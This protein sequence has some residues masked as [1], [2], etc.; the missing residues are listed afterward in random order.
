M[1]TNN[2]IPFIPF[3]ATSPITD[4]IALF[5]VVTKKLVGVKA[6]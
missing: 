4:Y 5:E 6:A 2:K 3:C 1:L